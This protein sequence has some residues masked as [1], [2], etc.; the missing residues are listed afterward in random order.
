MASREAAYGTIWR[1]FASPRFIHVSFD[2]NNAP[3][4]SGAWNA[5]KT[6]IKLPWK[7]RTCARVRRTVCAQINRMESHSKQSTWRGV[8]IEGIKKKEKRGGRWGMGRG[9][10]TETEQQKQWRWGDFYRWWNQE[11]CIVWEWCGWMAAI[12]TLLRCSPNTENWKW[13]S[14]WH[15]GRYNNTLCALCVHVHHTFQTVVTR[16]KRGNE[17]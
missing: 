16:V 7:L 11:I 8:G 10:E 15:S 2:I 6:I 9:G 17:L 3:V 14:W 13:A 1:P 4:S 5:S 12:R